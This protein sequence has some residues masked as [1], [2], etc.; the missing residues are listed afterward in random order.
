M[1]DENQFDWVP[2]YKELAEKL[3]PYKDNRQA[4]L[5][6]V[7]QIFEQTGITMP[8]LE[9][10]NQLVDIDPFTI[11]GFFNKH[12][13]K[14]NRKNIIS[15]IAKIFHLSVPIPTSSAGIPV[16]NNQNAV[17][18]PKLPKRDENDIPN[19]WKL[20]ETALAYAKNRTAENRLKVS[21][22]FDL[23]INI[24]GDGNS[25]IT[26]G[27]YWIAPDV[28]LNLDKCNIDYIYKTGNLDKDFIKTLPEVKDKKDEKMSA[29]T[30]FSITDKLD[31][32][33]Q[34]KDSPFK[35]FM[36][37]SLAAWIYVG[38]HNKEQQT[39]SQDVN[40][41]T[42]V[43]NP[44]TYGKANFLQDVYMAE[45]KYDTLVA[46]LQR[47]KNVILQGAPGVGKTYAAKRLA[48]SR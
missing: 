20:F 28:F 35:N 23:A 37:L 42:K 44:K 6:K 9:S 5:P 33:L 43:S 45:K 36:E 41:E 4:L 7:R 39:Q 14:D 21:H 2:F 40:D 3:L 15:T 19:L 16:V 29:S 10:D 22:Y 38:Q 25:K 32:Y 18:Y 48:Y 47:K 11:Y 24:F 26:M 12:L 1:E 34:S 27:L 46:L 17:F 8:S 31:T 13:K 30:Y